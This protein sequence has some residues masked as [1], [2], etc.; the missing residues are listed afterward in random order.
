MSKKKEARF[1]GKIKPLTDCKPFYMVVV[2]DAVNPP[3][4]KHEKYEDAFQEMLRLSKKENKT[5]YVLIS[6]TQVEQIPNVK[7]LSILQDLC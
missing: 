6:V 5:A 7:Q 4:L 3:K 1:E 2:E